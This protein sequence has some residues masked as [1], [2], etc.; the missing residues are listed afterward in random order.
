MRGGPPVLDGPRDGPVEYR[1]L[2][3]RSRIDVTSTA[4]LSHESGILQRLP[5]SFPDEVIIGKALIGLV[6]CDGVRVLERQDWDWV[7]INHKPQALS[8]AASAGGVADVVGRRGAARG[9]SR[10]PVGV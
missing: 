1:V 6:G 4:A 8:S 2:S 7:T 10:L 3:G 5:G 9:H